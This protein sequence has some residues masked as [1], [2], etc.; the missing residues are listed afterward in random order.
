MARV[1]TVL[2]LAILGGA[3]WADDGGAFDFG[4]DA[5][6]G[7]RTV[8]HDA[9]GTDD[10]FM[11]GETVTGRAAVSGSAH[12][13]GRE[14]TMAGAVGGDAYALGD[15]VAFEGDVAGDATV[16]GRAVSV[17]GV[18]GD[19][20][21]A[22]S[23]VRLGGAIGGSAMVAGEDVA[24]EAVVAGDVSLAAED[25]D[26]GAA[27]S[28]GGRLILYEE[29]PGEIE[30]PA[31]VVPEAR[32]ERREIDAWEGPRRPDWRRLV[33]GFLLGVIVVAGLAALI[34]ALVPEQLAAMRRQ[35][36]ARPFRT[37][38]LGFLT[39]SAVI[40]AAFLFAMTIIGL[41]LTP[42]MI[43]LAL[44]GGFAGYVVA[45]YAFGVGLLLAVGRAEPD[46]IGDRALAAGVGA[47]AA[48]IVGLIP[49]LGWLFVLALVLAG[50]GAITVRVMRPAFFATDAY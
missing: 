12:L 28:I 3:A 48:G 15:A 33:A 46:S 31:Q 40:G 49:F 22:G 16:A 13:L 47:L 50:I 38:W 35:V 20:R 5:F 26:W 45:A 37:L 1:L 21:I 29:E 24:F 27:A 23:T 41:L 2:L 17:A 4:G 36:L 7:G 18:G 25:V 19:L 6:R 30:V 43:F 32:I 9:Q 11:A 34:A 14:V 8:S 42:A 10:L 44:V 39:Q